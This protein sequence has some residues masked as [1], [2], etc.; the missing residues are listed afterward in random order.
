MYLKSLLKRQTEALYLFST[1]STEAE[2]FF[3]VVLGNANC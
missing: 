3:S 2:Y 1:Q